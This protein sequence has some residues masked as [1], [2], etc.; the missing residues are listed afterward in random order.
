MKLSN[1]IRIWDTLQYQDLGGLTYWEFENAINS[2]VGVKNDIPIDICQ[3]ERPKSL[4][5][6][7]R[8]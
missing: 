6:E 2:I 1:V 3:F 5:K 4:C 7:L 8:S